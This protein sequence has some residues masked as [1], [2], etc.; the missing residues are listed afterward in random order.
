MSTPRDAVNM[1]SSESALSWWM[2]RTRPAARL[3][4]KG[5]DAPAVLERAGVVIPHRV[6]SIIRFNSSSASQI[7]RA[8]D[9]PSRLSRCL[10]LGATEFLLEQD[11]GPDAVNAVRE[12]VLRAEQRAWPV[13]RTD[14]SALIGGT[15]TL[16]RLAQFCAFD[17][18]ALLT[19]A[20]A[21]SP[22]GNAV[23]PDTVV[24][25]LLAQISVTL[26]VE[27]ADAT[28]PQ[29]RLWTDASF[30]EYLEHTLSPSPSSGV[31]A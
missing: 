13:L 28:A 1:R 8:D 2:Q 15:A 18:E 4:V 5:P 17:F 10:R 29:L 24:M 25:T 23:A 3:G 11:E 16:Q 22:S 26:T 14:Y 6:N 12:S 7:V 27:C 21:A 19:G 30:G 9:A 20:T 31:H